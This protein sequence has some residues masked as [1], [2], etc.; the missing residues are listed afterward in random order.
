MLLCCWYCRFPCEVGIAAVAVLIVVLVLLL[1]CCCCCYCC[2]G[3]VS[4]LGNVE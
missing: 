1:L 3:I 4:V 2:C